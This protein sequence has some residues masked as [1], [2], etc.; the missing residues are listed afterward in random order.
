MSSRRLELQKILEAI[1]PNVY[2]QPPASVKL[3]YPAIVY[4]IDSIQREFA[5]NKQYVVTRGYE[6]TVMTTNPDNTIIDKMLELPL[7][8][9]K[10]TFCLDNLYHYTFELYY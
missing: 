10:T 3:K 4:S 9:F 5:D 1:V 8:S 7:C 2:F 6:V